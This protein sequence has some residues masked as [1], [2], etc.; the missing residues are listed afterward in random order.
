MDKSKQKIIYNLRE[1]N[2]LLVDD[3]EFMQRIIAGMLK[4]FGIGHI[5]SCLN[6]VEARELLTITLASAQSSS[7][8]K[9]I[10]IVLTDW[11]MPEGSG[12]NF[13][14]W[15]R[16]HKKD[17]VRFL[18]IIVI[19]AFMNEEFAR[20]ARD[21]G[22]DEIMAKPLSGEALAARILAVIDRQRFFIK[23]PGYFG[24]DR[25]RKNIPY[26]KKERR[27]RKAKEVIIHNERI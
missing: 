24:P 18:P 5:V 27:I 17:A 14:R 6:G 11:M 25:R 22:V 8:I 3:Y 23:S 21:A 13:I 10:D 12:E 26:V 9:S 16:N 19:S 7:N 20:K 4:A 15:I 2:L 1:F